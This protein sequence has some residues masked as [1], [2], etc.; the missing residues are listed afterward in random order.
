MKSFHLA[1]FSAAKPTN[2]SRMGEG[3]APSFL[4]SFRMKATDLHAF[5]PAKLLVILL[6]VSSIAFGQFDITLNLSNGISKHTQND[7]NNGLFGEENNWAYAGGIDAEFKYL[8]DFFLKPAIAVSFQSFGNKLSFGPNAPAHPN[9]TEIHR[10]NY[11]Q[12]NAGLSSI[13]EEKFEIG[14]F[15]VNGIL[16][17]HQHKLIATEPNNW[18]FAL[19]PYLTFHFNKLKLGV[20]Y[21]H[22]FN[23]IWDMNESVNASDSEVKNRAVLIKLGY[24]LFSL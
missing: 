13:L 9:E 24:N 14:L 8:P 21:Y 5:L 10:F 1:G 20:S 12:L 16:I 19:Q 23:S 22:G 17:S 6:F 11:L 7:L 2:K 15:A 3:F 18:D 4:P